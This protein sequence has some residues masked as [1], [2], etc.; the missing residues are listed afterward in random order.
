[1]NSLDLVNEH[2]A[3]VEANIQKLSL[4]LERLQRRKEYL[5]LGIS[6]AGWEAA[7]V[8]FTDGSGYNMNISDLGDMLQ[9]YEHAK[10][11]DV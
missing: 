5:R 7:K 11:K 1:M 9:A 3:Q 10:M 8:Y 2:I 6:P 4:E